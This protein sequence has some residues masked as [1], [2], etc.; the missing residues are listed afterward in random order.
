MRRTLIT[1]VFSCCYGIKLFFQPHVQL[2]SRCEG[3]GR[4]HSQATSPSWTMEIF[5]TI[6]HILSLSVG[7]DQGAG[8]SS[9]HFHEPESSL[10]RELTLFLEFCEICNFWVL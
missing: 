7:V 3:A 9:S 10:V 4:D 2:T 8:I 1:G 5:Y 6:D